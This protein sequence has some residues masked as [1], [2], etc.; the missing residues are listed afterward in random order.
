M[1]INTLFGNVLNYII[2]FVFFIPVTILRLIGL[3]L[4]TC[5][6]LGLVTF[7]NNAINDSIQWMRFAWPVLQWLP[8]D[9]IWGLVSAELL[10]LIFFYIF[11]HLPMI[12]NFVGRWWWLILIL[13]LFGGIISSFLGNDWRTNDIF[14]DVFDTAPTSTGFGGGGYGGGGGGGW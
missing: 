7:S 3:L 11:D 13:F 8:W 12:M 6:Q 14:T 5:D 9:V 10:L 1:D 4:P 2:G